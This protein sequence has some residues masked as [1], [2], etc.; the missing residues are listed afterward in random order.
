MNQEVLAYLRTFIS[1]SQYEWPSML[2]SAMLAINNRNTIIGM[3]PFF[4]T[5]G[6]HAE[7]IQQ[8]QICIK[9]RS[10]PAKRAED[11]IKRLV[12]AQEYAQAAM[13]TVQQRMESS[14]NLKRQ[15]Q[16]RF[17]IGDIVWLNL[18]NVPTPQISKKLS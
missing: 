1:Y 4:L 15:P 3:S 11:F 8:T 13:A 10:V 6:Y 12:D 7:P 2:P 14:A 18:K 5:H 9:R 17:Q 16:E